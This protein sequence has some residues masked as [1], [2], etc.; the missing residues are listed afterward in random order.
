M[1]LTQLQTYVDS[2]T[3]GKQ[4]VGGANED[5]GGANEAPLRPN[6]SQVPEKM[7][8]E[9][10]KKEVGGQDV[11]KEEEVEHEVKEASAGSAS[12]PQTEVCGEERCHK[13]SQI[14]E[15]LCDHVQSMGLCNSSTTEPSCDD[16]ITPSIPT[17]LENST[18]EGE[19]PQPSEDV[20]RPLAVSSTISVEGEL[21]FCL[22]QFTSTELLTGKDMYACDRCTERKQQQRRAAQK[23]HG[24]NGRGGTEGRTDIELGTVRSENGDVKQHGADQSGTYVGVWICMYVWVQ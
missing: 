3:P 7:E 12:A 2:N 5:E 10:E 8:E 23:D 1:T 21:E 24:E 9:V 17:E 13:E 22:T 14:Q 16:D 20:P 18:R 15:D 6:G 19:V 4:E 11:E